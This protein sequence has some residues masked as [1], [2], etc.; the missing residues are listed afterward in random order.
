MGTGEGAVEKAFSFQ[1]Q[2]QF[3]PSIVCGNNQQLFATMKIFAIT[4]AVIMTGMT[5]A[6]PT[7][8]TSV[9]GTTADVRLKRS[10]AVTEQ[11]VEETS[12]RQKRSAAGVTEQT[13]EETSQR[14]KRS[15][16]LEETTETY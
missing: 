3:K 5:L 10:E 11:T 2:N 15:A 9:L 13:V 7:P 1:T 6:A 16:S 12:Q 14:Q 4:I 8:P